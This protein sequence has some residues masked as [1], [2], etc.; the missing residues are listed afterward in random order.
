MI[1]GVGGGEEGEGLARGG[2]CQQKMGHYRLFNRDLLKLPHPLSQGLFLCHCRA[3]PL[4]RKP[5]WSEIIDASTRV[6][7]VTIIT[8]CVCR[9]V[10]KAIST[11]QPIKQL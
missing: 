2:E 6:P 8:H 4:Q 9:E 7:V 10:R 5:V 11:G 3:D 1:T